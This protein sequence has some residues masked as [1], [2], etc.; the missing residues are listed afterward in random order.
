MTNGQFTAI[1]V[2]HVTHTISGGLTLWILATKRGDSLRVEEHRKSMAAIYNRI[3]TTVSEVRYLLQQANQ[4]HPFSLLKRGCL[5]SKEVSTTIWDS[6]QA[7]SWREAVLL[8]N[9]EN[10]QTAAA[11]VVL[12]ATKLEATST[13]ESL[14]E[15][16]RQLFKRDDKG[17]VKCCL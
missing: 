7:A 15:S 3:I 10:I 5:K 9:T 12:T 14:N 4:E 1:A 2:P 6:N 16:S 11:V 8:A 13:D 17:D